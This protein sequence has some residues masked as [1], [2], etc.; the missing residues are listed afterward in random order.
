MTSTLISVVSSAAFF[1]RRL[2]YD[3]SGKSQRSSKCEPCADRHSWWMPFQE[4]A[5]QLPHLR[6]LDTCWVW[7][8]ACSLN[9]KIVT[10]VVFETGFLWVALGVLKLTLSTRL[11]LNPEI[12]LPL[13]TKWQINGMHHHFPAWV[14]QIFKRET[15]LN[16]SLVISLV[17]KCTVM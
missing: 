17:Y 7:A 4:T 16:F 6:D 10:E 1:P 9:Y 12:C 14:V 2:N 15:K 8:S 3:S 5:L 11:A 13:P